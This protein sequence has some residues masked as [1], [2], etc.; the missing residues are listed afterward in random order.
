MIDRPEVDGVVDYGSKRGG[1]VQD[2]I[3][4]ANKG[5]TCGYRIIGGTILCEEVIN[6]ECLYCW[7]SS[8]CEEDNTDACDS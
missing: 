3:E 2:E 6:I 5:V 8:C 7:V 1:K 4:E